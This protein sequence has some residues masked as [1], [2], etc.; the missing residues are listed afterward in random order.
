MTGDYINSDWGYYNS[1]SNGGAQNHQWRTPLFDYQNNE[2]DYV[3]NLRNTPSGIRFAKAQVADV[4][5]IILLP[6]TWISAYYTLNNTNQSEASFNSNVISSS[7]WN[8][9]FQTHGAV[10]LPAAGNR[11]GTLVNGPILGHYWT[12]AG[13]GS[14]AASLDFDNTHLAPNGAWGRQ[15]GF[16]VRLIRNAQ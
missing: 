7:S 13:G 6:D 4:D 1:I 12:T 3:F 15:N 8:S 2:W 16:S 10:F 5:G 9:V 11:L 14:C